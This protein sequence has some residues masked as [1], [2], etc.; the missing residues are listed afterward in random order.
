VT[1]PRALSFGAAA[2]AYAQARPSYPIDAVRW[3]I[4]DPACPVAQPAERVA[5]PVRPVLDLAA[6]TGK[7]AS[8][9]LDLGR[10]V[11]AVEPD[12]AMRRLIDP[13]VHVVGGRA[14]HIPLRDG[15]LDAVVVGQ[16]W[17]WFERAAAFAECRRVLRPGGQLGLSWNLL[18]DRI[19]WVREIVEMAGLEDRFSRADER[20]EWAHHA[21]G[22]WQRRQVAHER[23]GGPDT[24]VADLRSRSVVIMLPP[25]EQDALLARA[26]ALIPPG[27]RATPFVCDA[28]RT[29]PR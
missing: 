11:V 1:N 13:R 21:P 10:D 17:H 27:V 29:V 28:W 25:A 9:L 2:A 6:G 3:L 20:G 24:I 26:A 23:P 19:G 5:D 22:T 18:D 7:L 14:E 16:A 8:V 4:A 15:V 12:S